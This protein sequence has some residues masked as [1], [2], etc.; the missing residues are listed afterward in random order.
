MTQLNY[1]QAKASIFFF[2]T[3]ECFS[4]YN[5]HLL[6]TYHVPGAKDTNK[7]Q[8]HFFHLWNSQHSD[9]N[10]LC[11]GAVKKERRARVSHQHTEEHNVLGVVS[12]RERLDIACLGEEAELIEQLTL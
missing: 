7:N 6:S 1:L 12:N 2:F 4:S 5:R 3:V 10:V 8:F 11:L 9:R